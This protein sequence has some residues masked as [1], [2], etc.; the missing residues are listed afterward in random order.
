MI[1]IRNPIVLA[2]VQFVATLLAAI[3]VI[4]VIWGD[5]L[6]E[7]LELGIVFGIIFVIIGYLTTRL[8]K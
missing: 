1:E 6:R 7:A 2:V 5:P 3:L 4:Y 8:E